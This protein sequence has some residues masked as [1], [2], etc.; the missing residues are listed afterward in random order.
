MPDAPL[1]LGSVM[2]TRCYGN[3]GLWGSAEEQAVPKRRIGSLGVF[4][5]A[6]LTVLKDLSLVAGSSPSSFR[7]G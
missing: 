3:L 7:D 4:T 5:G 1:R 2:V 6:S